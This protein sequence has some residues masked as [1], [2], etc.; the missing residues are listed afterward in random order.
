MAFMIGPL[1]ETDAW[2][3]QD[4]VKV[5]ILFALR[6]DK[7]SRFLSKRNTDSIQ[8]ILKSS[9][10]TS[11]QIS[12]LKLLIGEIGTGFS[13]KVQRVPWDLISSINSRMK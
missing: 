9:S 10:T 1:Q 3:L 13:I 6:I 7:E 5:D 8:A 2:R 11:D 4:K 12:V